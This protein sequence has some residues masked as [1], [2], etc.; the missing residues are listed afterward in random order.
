MCHLAWVIP[1]VRMLQ[2]SVQ[3]QNKNNKLGRGKT[4]EKKPLTP[5][6]IHNICGILSNIFSVQ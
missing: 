4:E 3:Q 5:M 2:V 6:N 1:Q